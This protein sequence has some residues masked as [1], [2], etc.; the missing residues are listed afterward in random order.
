MLHDEAVHQDDGCLALHYM[1]EVWSNENS[2]VDASLPAGHGIVY[3][4]S[5][6]MQPLLLIKARDGYNG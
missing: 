1:L 4:S 5:I 6:P 3:V 2:L